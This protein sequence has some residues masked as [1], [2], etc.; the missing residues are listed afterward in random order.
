MVEIR[1]L[2]VIHDD[3]VLESRQHFFQLRLRGI[4]EQGIA[5]IERVEIAENMTLRVQEKRIETAAYGQIPDIVGNHAVQPAHAVATDQGDFGPVIQAK[6]T[7]SGNQLGKFGS[8]F[9]EVSGRRSR[10]VMNSSGTHRATLDYTACAENDVRR[11]KREQALYFRNIYLL[12]PEDRMKLF[13]TGAV[14][15]LI[16]ASTSLLAQSDAQ[17]VLDRF[18]SM[19]GTWEG[20]SPAGDAR[21]V[22]YRLMAGGS[23]VMAESHNGSGDMTSMF[24]V[25]GDRLLMTHFCPAGNQPRMTATISPDLKM[26]SFE[27]LDATNLPAPAAGHMHRAVYMFSA[28]DHY[29]EEWTWKHEGK[30]TKFHYEMQRKKYWLSFVQDSHCSRPLCYLFPREPEKT[31]CNYS[32]RRRRQ[33]SDSRGRQGADRGGRGD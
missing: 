19:A 5:A 31:H 12:E 9:P 33:G 8:H 32:R 29:S 30:D 6:N 22:T 10:V 25:D 24:Y 1:N 2:Y 23:A 20:K 11:H 13:R 4:D 3:V 17:K 16:L 14:L 21:E 15:T 28:D 7:A 26:V 18:K 27:F